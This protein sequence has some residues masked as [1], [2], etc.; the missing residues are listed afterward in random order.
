MLLG[1]GAVIAVALAFFVGGIVGFGRGY[2]MGNEVAH[3]GDANMV[4]TELQKHDA[5]ASRQC[6][7]LLFESIVDTAITS[8]DVKRQLGSSEFDQWGYRDLDP[9]VESMMRRVAE[10]RRRHPRVPGTNMPAPS[11]GAA[12]T[13]SSTLQEHGR[14]AAG[15]GAPA[16]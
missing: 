4:V 16:P 3:I 8:Y 13:P 15:V 14:G 5:A 9:T 6:S 1:V 11:Q 10:Y 2:L 12:G 7:G